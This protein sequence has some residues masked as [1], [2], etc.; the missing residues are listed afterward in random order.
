[1]SSN[2]IENLKNTSNKQ[3]FVVSFENVDFYVK[4][5]TVKEMTDYIA[6]IEKYNDNEKQS[7]IIF[8][9]TACDK[10]GALIFDV[11]NSEHIEIIDN[12]PIK[13]RRA[14]DEAFLRENGLGK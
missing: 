2:K 7:S 9:L 8:G 10:S 1:M 14:V 11:S 6:E 3:V 13:I 5:L 12:L 4:M